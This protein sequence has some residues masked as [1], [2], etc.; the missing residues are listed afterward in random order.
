MPLSFTFFISRIPPFQAGWRSSLDAVRKQPSRSEHAVRGDGYQDRQ[1]GMP[2]PISQPHSS[3]AGG[4]GQNP[5]VL[6]RIGGLLPVPLHLPLGARAGWRQQS[7]PDTLPQ[8]CR[9]WSCQPQEI[10]KI[11][12]LISEQVTPPGCRN[13]GRVPL[14]LHAG[15]EAGRRVLN[16]PGPTPQKHPPLALGPFQTRTFQ[17]DQGLQT[18]SQMPS[19]TETPAWA[20]TVP[21]TGI[22][23]ALS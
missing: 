9:H 8:A 6:P 10:F 3:P 15:K 7:G 17:E 23:W 12:P 16:P 5:K 2:A 19:P 1:P 13:A 20:L 4:R 11:H 18:S 22:Q 14:P 21:D